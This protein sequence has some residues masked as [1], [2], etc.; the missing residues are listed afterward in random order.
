MLAVHEQIVAAVLDAARLE[1]GRGGGFTV[2]IALAARLCALVLTGP[3]GEA[4]VTTLAAGT[5][6]KLA[7]GDSR[8]ALEPISA[9]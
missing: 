1:A 2:S 3:D 6:A 9:R 5:L 7:A 8:G 4:Q